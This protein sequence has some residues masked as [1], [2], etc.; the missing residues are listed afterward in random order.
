[1]ARATLGERLVNVLRF[2]GH[3]EHLA[4]PVMIRQFGIGS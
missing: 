1:M 3:I 2:A 4:R